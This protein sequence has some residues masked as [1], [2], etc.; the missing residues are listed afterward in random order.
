MVL[1]KPIKLNLGSRDKK[2]DGYISVDCDPHSGVDIVAD[3]RN[4]SQFETGSVREIFASNILEHF[5]HTETLDVL[6]EWFRVLE[7][8]G[9]LY[10]SVP[11][12]DVAMD[13][14]MK[15]GLKETWLRNFIWGDQEY[16]TAFHYTGFDE[17]S[18]RNLVYQAG[19]SEFSR[20]DRL[21]VSHK[22]DCS[23]NMLTLDGDPTGVLVSLNAVCVK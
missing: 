20:V 18:L 13:V 21:P 5:P 19:F 12:F 23:N 22:D 14:Y 6:K 15:H 3:V 10:L 17:D 16:K 11:D 7:P 2:I 4:L 1:T 9:I 8:K